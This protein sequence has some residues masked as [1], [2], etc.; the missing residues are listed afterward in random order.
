MN[1]IMLE[2]IGVVIG[3]NTLINVYHVFILND[4]K[5]RLFRMENIHIKETTKN[6]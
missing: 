5:Q 3:L 6:E 1:N 2:I 4:I